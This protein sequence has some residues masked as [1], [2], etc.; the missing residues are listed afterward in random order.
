[1]VSMS[2]AMRPRTVTSHAKRF[3]SSQRRIARP[4]NREGGKMA[5]GM[6]QVLQG[7]TEEQYDK[8]DEQMFGQSPPPADQSPA[9]MIVHSAGPAENGWYIY[10]IWESKDAF[11]R[12]TEDQLMPAVRAVMGDVPPLPGSEPQFFDIE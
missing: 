1:I 2:A 10:D 8:V 9:G 6:L 5:V 12:F 4:F 11:N 7:I 3:P